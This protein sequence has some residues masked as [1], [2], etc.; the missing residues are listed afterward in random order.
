MRRM[1]MSILAL[2]LFAC[3]VKA[4]QAPAKSPTT[5][6]AKAPAAAPTQTPAPAPTFKTQKEKISYAIGMEMGKGVKSQGIDVD[7]G[8]LAQGLRDAMSG[9]KPQMSEEELKQVITGLQQEMRQKQMQMQEAAAAENKTKGDTFLAENSKK[10]GVVALPDGLQYKVLS[11]GTG[12]KPAETDTVLC[13]YKGTFLDGTEFDSSAQAG[14][15]VPFEVK[16]VIP[17]FKEVLQLMPVGSKWQVFIPSNLA[18]GERGAGNVIGPNATLIFEIELVSIQE[19]QP[20]Q[21]AGGAPKQ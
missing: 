2:G 21:P 6:P 3:G 18:Y 20:T 15:P 11:P 9:A 17:G 8:I 1:G 16:N 7:P 5:P 4:Q 14:K 12:K 13:N 10:D 19:T